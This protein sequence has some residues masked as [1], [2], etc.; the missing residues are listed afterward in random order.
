[1]I[2]KHFLAICAILF[3]VA[4][5]AQPGSSCDDPIVLTQD[6]RATIP[7]PCVMWYTASTYDLPIHVYFSPFN[8]NSQVGPDVEVDFTCTPG[9]YEDPMIDSLVNLVSDFSI[10][11]PIQFKSEL[12]TGNGR[13]EWD[14]SVSKTYR[15]Q[16][17]GFGVLYAVK[18]YVKVTYHEGGT[19]SLSPDTAFSSCMSS[20]KIVA[21]DDTIQVASNDEE[22]VYVFP[23]TAWKND[24]IRFVWTGEGQATVYVAEQE[25]QFTASTSNPYVFSSFSVSADTPHKLYSNQM[26]DYISKHTGEGLFYAKVV[27]S[28]PGRLVVEKIPMAAADGGAETLEYGK[29]TQVN[30]G[31]QLYCFPRTWKATEIKSS[32]S[33]PVRMLISTS[34]EFLSE[35]DQTVISIQD[36]SMV[37]GKRLL[38]LSSFEMND[39]VSAAT[40]DYLYVRFVASAAVTITPLEWTPAECVDESYLIRPNTKELIKDKSGNVVYRLRYSDFTDYDLTIQWDGSS[41]LPTFIAE[42]CTFSLTS[43]NAALLVKP[44]FSIKRKG[45][46]LIDAASVNAW[47]SRIGEDGFFFV[48]FKPSAM[49]NVTFAT[50]KKEETPVVPDPVYTTIADTVCYGVTYEWNGQKYTTSGEYQQTLLAAN[51]A[52]SVV[53]LNLVVLPQVQPVVTDVTVEYGK[54]YEWN[55]KVYAE[56]TTDTITLQ[57]ANGCDYLAILKLTVLDKPASP[58]VLKSIELKIN[59]QLTL[60]LDSAFTIYRINYTAWVATGATLSW[61]G[62]EPLHTFVAETCEF[63][64]APYNKYVHAYVTV[65]AEGV[66]V[67]DKAKLT[68]LAAYVDEDGYLYVRFLSEKE[69]VLE[70]K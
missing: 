4:I 50:D 51:G 66:A 27:A 43:N 1:M 58:C 32:Q 23:Y 60:N 54:T 40:G 13:N 49:G 20:A 38:Q 39:V 55:N 15:E 33:T 65:P 11:F 64:V 70:V 26:K 6:Y 18:A 48:R 69:G 8:D 2:K 68:E 31:D 59:D 35:T 12:V 62:V 63:A 67:L 46:Q 3:S 44:A 42:T 14:L 36:F 45:S 16:L 25:C 47:E 41:T 56:T 7:G 19:I 52:D 17:A 9:I 30:S 53:T 57:D 10:T 29:T 5:F 37:D 61:S 21:L 34:S 24:S 22:T 28:A